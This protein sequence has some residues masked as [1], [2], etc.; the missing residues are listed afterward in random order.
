MHALTVTGYLVLVLVLAM[1]LLAAAPH[2]RPGVV[3]SFGSMLEEVMR[4]RPARVTIMVF[5]WWLGWHFLTG[6]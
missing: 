4:E 2:V 3:V 1:A 6:A 5:W